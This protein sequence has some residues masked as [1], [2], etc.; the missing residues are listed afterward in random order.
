M[1]EV[2][3]RYL[4]QDISVDYTTNTEHTKAPQKDLK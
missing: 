2:K 1:D 3:F 4:N